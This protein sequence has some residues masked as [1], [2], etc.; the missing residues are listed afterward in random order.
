MLFH[1]AFAK[2]MDPVMASKNQPFLRLLGATLVLVS[3]LSGT[4]VFAAEDRLARVLDRG[5]VRVCI[6]PAYYA[7]TYRNPRDGLLR[8]IDIDLSHGFAE[9]LGVRLDYVEI[10][11]PQLLPALE[12]DKC[13]IAMMAVSINQERMRRADFSKPYL[14]SSIVLVAPK[15]S[16]VIRSWDDIDRPGVVIAVTQGTAM[17]EY[18]RASLRSA[19]LMV[20]KSTETREEEVLS[21]RADAF[22]TDYAYSRRV[23]LEYD[24]AR[25]IEPRL[26]VGVSNYGY[27]VP[28]NSPDWLARVEQFVTAIKK[29]GRLK[30]AAAAHGLSTI[31]VLD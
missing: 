6:W 26:A 17:E 27:A 18:F 25:V 14:R 3:I 15:A 30:A 28:K 23:E 22:A 8:G 5:V 13:D 19:R 31:A 16:T 29:D 7:I 12:G 11:L 4:K 2:T 10:N 1:G 21:G 20:L 24:W 9:D